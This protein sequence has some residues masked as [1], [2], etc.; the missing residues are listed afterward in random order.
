MQKRHAKLLIYTFEVVYIRAKRIFKLIMSTLETPLVRDKKENKK[1]IENDAINVHESM[2]ELN[3]LTEIQFLIC[4]SC[5]WC[6]SYINWSSS[7]EYETLTKCVMCK[8]RIESIPIGSDE[9]YK[10][11]YNQAYGIELTFQRR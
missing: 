7:K 9:S 10:V 4:P 6:A 3:G 5:F 2:T 8:S 11:N 1:E